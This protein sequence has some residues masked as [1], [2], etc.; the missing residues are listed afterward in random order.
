[1]NTPSKDTSMMLDALQSAVSKA[2]DKKRRL[3]QYAV[4]WENGKIVFTEGDRPVE[5]PEFSSVEAASS[6]YHENSEPKDRNS[7]NKNG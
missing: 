6:P 4:F 5:Q 7:D 3:G 1:M 2:L